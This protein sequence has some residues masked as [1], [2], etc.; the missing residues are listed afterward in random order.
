ME[1]AQ[2]SGT[3][4]GA[5]AQTVAGAVGKGRHRVCKGFDGRQTATHPLASPPRLH[6]FPSLRLFGSSVPTTTPLGGFLENFAATPRPL[7]EGDGAVL[8][9]SCFAS[10]TTCSGSGSSA[11][12]PP[13][14]YKSK[15]S[16]KHTAITATLPW[17][18]MVRATCYGWDRQA[19]AHSWLRVRQNG[20]S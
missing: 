19:G 2:T 14:K 1:A 7:A 15:K 18:R 20:P 11:P 5:C 4:F 8:L 6:A 3:R 9:T 12:L 16:P 17:I 13:Q 10:P